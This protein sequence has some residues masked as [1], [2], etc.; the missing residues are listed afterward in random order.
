[1]ALE[2]INSGFDAL[3]AGGALR[4]TV[5]FQLHSGAARGADPEPRV[6]GGAI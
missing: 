4:Q 2:D 1:M 6:D 3:A 5:Q